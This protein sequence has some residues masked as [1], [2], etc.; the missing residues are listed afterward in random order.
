MQ[1]WADTLRI[2][3]DMFHDA[4]SWRTEY[5]P[6]GVFRFGEPFASAFGALA[7]LWLIACTLS[8]ALQL[9][10]WLLPAAGL[11]LR[12]SSSWSVGMW[13]A[14]VSFHAL[15]GLHAFK[16]PFALLGCTALAGAARYAIPNALPVA[17][18][19]RREWRAVRALVALFRRSHHGLL[20]ACFLGFALL[21]ALRS[22]VVPPLG[23]D[24]LT[25]H[26][27][28][29]ALWL[30]TGRFTFDDGVG[31]YDFYRHFI[32]GGEVLS[33]W[34]MLPFHS[35]LLV[36]LAGVFQWLGVGLATWALA[37][38]IGLREPFAAT[39]AAVL[40][41]APT[42]Q[43]E[44]NSGYVELALNCALI[45]GIALAVHCMRRPSVQGALLCA[46]ALGVAASIKLPGI[47]PAAIMAT[48]LAL[49]L[50][51]SRRLGWRAKLLAAVGGSLCALL[52]VAPFLLRALLDTG[53]PLSPMPVKL[54]G[55]TLGVASSA[56]HWY[57]D[58]PQLTAYSWPTEKK[59]LL[60]LFSPLSQ[61]NESLGT[62]AL[63]PLALFP[64][65]LVALLRHKPLVALSLLCA[66]AAPVAAHFS[67]SISAVRLLR[68][69]S[70]AR[71]LIPTLALVVPISLAWCT[72]DAVLS[73]AYRR[74][75]LGYPLVASVVAVRRGWGDWETHDATLIALTLALSATLL[76]WLFRRHPLQACL[77]GLVL[78]MAGLTLL[79]ARR[80]DTRALAYQKG[81]A[82]HGF[83]RF[84]AE[85]P[86]MIDEPTRPHH[87]AIT[88]GP[89]HSSDKWF[90]YFFLGARFQNSVQYV[91]P[92][93]DG[94]IA[95]FGPHGDL[96]ARADKASWLQRLAA[97]GIT[98]VVTFPP[99]SLEQAFM[100]SEPTR[101]EQ[102]SGAD[103]WGLY[104]LKA[105][106]AAR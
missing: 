17:H 35:D 19:L 31:C 10:R 16:L 25:Y 9:L 53:Y 52:P 11:P 1:G 58:R 3:R 76:G 63:I 26:G 97:A 20:S 106:P 65:G 96:D 61:I 15:R 14:E 56:M 49:R 82:L 44:L 34:A 29:A 8:A 28:R 104:R 91:T 78:W 71:F 27:P 74:L 103:D 40:M 45:S 102:M 68:S 80:D 4:W 95:H 62:L 48:V 41:F 75:L 83:P 21:V 23:W 22:L 70:A 46:V 100:D 33:A 69:V 98:D 6:S 55:H 5:A 86:A 90:H 43:L 85:A 101:F 54:F 39:S 67:P 24:T 59:A 81:F 79:Q 51:A 88:G 12:W 77:L 87:L 30:T 32:S 57:Q 105:V 60:A 38:A 47:P 64:L 84:W 66:A 73:R 13:L 2:A 89:D 7:S 94:G 93:R 92:T 42:L 36:N 18:L 50:L 99:R 37:R 72:P